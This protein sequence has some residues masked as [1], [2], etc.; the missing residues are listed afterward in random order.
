M[1]SAAAFRGGRCLSTAMVS[2]AI[3]EKLQWQ[4]WRE[5]TFEMSPNTVLLG[6]P[7][8]SGIHVL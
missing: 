2:G 8:P 6:H 7:T 4:C 3:M 1:Q 5:H